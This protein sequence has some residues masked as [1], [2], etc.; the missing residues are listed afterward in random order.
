MSGCSTGSVT[1]AE[2]A[3]PLTCPIVPSRHYC[4]YE[5]RT[6]FAENCDNPSPAVAQCARLPRVTQLS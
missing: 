6:H 1:D 3:G 5:A 2:S 4:C